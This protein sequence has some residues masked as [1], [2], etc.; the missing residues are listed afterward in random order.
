MYMCANHLLVCSG[1]N[2][3]QTY[4]QLL[5]LDA[6]LS[7]RGSQEPFEQVWPA[8]EELLAACAQVAP[9]L[10]PSH[11]RMLRAILQ[12]WS[13]YYYRNTGVYKFPATL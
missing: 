13:T 6:K 1:Q 2:A 4:D 7:L 11:R 9:R 12:Y 3:S 5:D 8:C 10:E